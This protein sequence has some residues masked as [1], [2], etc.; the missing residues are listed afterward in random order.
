MPKTGAASK[1]ISAFINHKL[2]KRHG[3]GAKYARTLG[4]AKAN[5][6]LRYR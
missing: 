6:A 1:S 2:A 4:A 5:P 3:R